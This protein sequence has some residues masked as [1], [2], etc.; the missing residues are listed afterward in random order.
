MPCH[1]G[2]RFYHNLSTRQ[3]PEL[4]EQELTALRE[5][6]LREQQQEQLVLRHPPG[7]NSYYD[8]TALA[9]ACARVEGLHLEGHPTDAVQVQA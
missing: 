3:Q 6:H 7:P 9:E 4:L 2:V 5:L 8:G 1:T